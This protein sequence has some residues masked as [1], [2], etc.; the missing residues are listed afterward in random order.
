MFSK[1]FESVK[2][3]DI[4]AISTTI[5]FFVVFVTVIIWVL[6]LKH[7]Y[8][9]KWRQIPFD[10]KESDVSKEVFINKHIGL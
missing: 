10:D 2:G 7:E 9:Q 5:I 8:V 3:V 4:I 1:I 6:R